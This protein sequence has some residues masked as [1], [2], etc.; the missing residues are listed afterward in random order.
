VLSN[1]GLAERGFDLGVDAC[2][3]RSDGTPS[4]SA[5][6]VATT[7]EAI[8]G[9]VFADGGNDAVLRVM[10]HLGFLDHDFFLVTLYSFNHMF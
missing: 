9:A 1:E 3:F 4:T 2:V 6:M 8:V 7:L 5:K 10:N